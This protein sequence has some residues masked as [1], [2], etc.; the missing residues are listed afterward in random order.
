MREVF[1]SKNADVL[2]HGVS[3]L[4][5]RLQ[6]D[7]QQS[8]ISADVLFLVGAVRVTSS[9]VHDNVNLS[10]GLFFFAVGGFTK[11]GC[12]LFKNDILGTWHHNH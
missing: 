1:P 5:Y 10:D 7:S 3:P 8:P 4:N 6:H 12:L 11:L 2:R 9:L